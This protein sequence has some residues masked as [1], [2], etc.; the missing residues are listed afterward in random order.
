M[1][2]STA[3]VSVAEE[4]VG[5]EGGH[6]VQSV[7]VCWKSYCRVV[8]PNRDAQEIFNIQVLGAF[9]FLSGIPRPRAV[10]PVRV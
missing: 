6:V 7:E 9:F 3:V 5:G 10:N 8:Q 4:V 1:I 2:R